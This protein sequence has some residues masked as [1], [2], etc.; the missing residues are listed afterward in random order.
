MRNGDARVTFKLKPKQIQSLLIAYPQFNITK[1]ETF[2][3]KDLLVHAA[4]D[5]WRH[6]IET[7]VPEDNPPALDPNSRM[8]EV[9]ANKAKRLIVKL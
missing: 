8:A 6:Q 7:P 5:S 3:L 1:G 9:F 4:K 2:M